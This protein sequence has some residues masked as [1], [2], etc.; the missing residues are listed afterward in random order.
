MMCRELLDAVESISG[1][2]DPSTAHGGSLRS[3]QRFA[4]DD[5]TFWFMQR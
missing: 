3:P 1:R 5:I 2:R 4:Q